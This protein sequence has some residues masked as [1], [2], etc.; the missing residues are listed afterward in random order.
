[1]MQGQNK[2]F[3]AVALLVFFSMS[4][5]YS[6][7]KV[8]QT[9]QRLKKQIVKVYDLDGILLLGKK[10][11]D[12]G[13]VFIATPNG[14]IGK[15]GSITEVRGTYFEYRDGQMVNTYSNEMPEII[16]DRFFGKISGIQ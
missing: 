14:G 6:T 15:Y 8:A 11:I 1:M 2:Y 9:E 7:K 3:I 12:N 10:D 5:L 16:S 4:Y 13:Y